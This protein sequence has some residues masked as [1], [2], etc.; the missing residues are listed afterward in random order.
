MRPGLGKC[1]PLR[2]GICARKQGRIKTTLFCKKAIIQKTRIWPSGFACGPGPP[3]SWLLGRPRASGWP[4]RLPM[5]TTRLGPPKRKKLSP[6]VCDSLARVC[7][8]LITVDRPWPS[9]V[10][11]SR[12]ALPSALPFPHQQ[13]RHISCTTC[14][15]SSPAGSRNCKALAQLQ[16]ALPPR[17]C[18]RGMLQPPMPGAPGGAGAGWRV[19]SAAEQ[20]LAAPGTKKRDSRR[21]PVGK[22]GIKNPPHPFAIRE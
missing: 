18:M 5:A 8:S 2:Q 11:M 7:D 12:C 20:A 3:L 1:R 9:A 15:I 10:F 16:S 13:Y 14:R 19:A 17:T 4:G 22:K 6:L 21:A